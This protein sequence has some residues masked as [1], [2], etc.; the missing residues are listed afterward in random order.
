MGLWGQAASTNF[1]GI[2]EA[3]QESLKLW[4]NAHI[5]IF[6]PA[7]PDAEVER[8]N[9]FADNRIGRGHEILFDSGPNGAI[10][11]PSGQANSVDT[12]GQLGTVLGMQFQ[13]VREDMTPLP[14]GL[15]VRVMDGGNNTGLERFSYSLV[16]AITGSIAWGDIIETQVVGTVLRPEATTG[17][18]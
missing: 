8:Y 1:A 6:D 18:P 2:Q 5:I 11:L 17:E 16:S 9:P 4:F 13:T 7:V 14:A 15:R 3:M 12:G 10:V